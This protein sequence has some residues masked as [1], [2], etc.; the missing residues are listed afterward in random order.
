MHLTLCSLVLKSNFFFLSVF[1]Y[2][3][4]RFF[5]VILAQQPSQVQTVTF[6]CCCVSV[7]LCMFRERREITG[8][9]PPDLSGPCGSYSNGTFYVFAGC[10]NRQYTNEVRFTPLSLPRGE[11]DDASCLCR[12]SAVSSRSTITRG[13]ERLTPREPRHRP[14]SI[15]PAGCT[16]TGEAPNMNN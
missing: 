6:T 12:C 8:E 5:H 2:E 14:G 10:D 7:C 3:S 15:T 1:N 4:N 13:R 9:R 16:E 11:L